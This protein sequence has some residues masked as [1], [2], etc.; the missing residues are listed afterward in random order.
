MLD[1]AEVTL[2]GDGRQLLALGEGS[3]RGGGFLY[4]LVVLLLRDKRDLR[5]LLLGLGGGGALGGGALVV[6]YS[7]A[8]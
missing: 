7:M 2:A 3:G 5:R 4:A 6:A 1:A 8:C